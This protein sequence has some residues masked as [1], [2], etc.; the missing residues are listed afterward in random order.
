MRRLIASL[1]WGTFIFGILRSCTRACPRLLSTC[2]SWWVLVSYT[3][4]CGHMTHPPGLWVSNMLALCGCIWP[5]EALGG[6]NRL[7]GVT[8]W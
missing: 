3:W 7:I 5:E 8:I 1:G 6:T 2:A 4:G